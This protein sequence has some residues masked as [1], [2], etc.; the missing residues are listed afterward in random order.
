MS[1]LLLWI[2][3]SQI[4]L[5]TEKHNRCPIQTSKLLLALMALETFGFVQE[6]QERFSLTVAGRRFTRAATSEKRTIIRSLLLRDERVKRIVDLLE[7]SVK[8]RLPRRL[9]NE[10]FGLEADAPVS[11]EEIRG[12]LGWAEASGL[13]GYDRVTDEIINSGLGSD[14]KKSG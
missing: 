4:R 6:G 13:F 12:F 9:V 14:Y 3:G 11:E 2:E 5:N 1:A 7:T 10:S 8:C